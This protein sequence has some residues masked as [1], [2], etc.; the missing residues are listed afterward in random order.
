VIQAQGLLLRPWRVSDAASLVRHANSRKIWIN[1]KDRFP[2]PYT[3]SDADAWITMTMAEPGEPTQ[4]AIEVAGEAVGGI[5]FERLGDVYR[6]GAEIG[7]WLGESYWGRG[8]TTAAVRALSEHAFA[9]FDFERLQASVFAW[10]AA[11]MRVLEKAGYGLEG[12]LARS[13]VKDGRIVDSLLY[14]RLR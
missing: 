12:R 14:A 10:N 8:L 2:H 4:F 13:V 5:G 7:Y 9:H 6:R 1:L 11:S 3:A